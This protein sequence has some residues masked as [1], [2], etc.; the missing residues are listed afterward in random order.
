MKTQQLYRF[1]DHR[2]SSVCATKDVFKNG[3]YVMVMMTA[4]MV[5]M[6]AK[7]FVVGKFFFRLALVLHYCRV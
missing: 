2:N 6:R 5:L 3:I 7:L 4:A 1:V